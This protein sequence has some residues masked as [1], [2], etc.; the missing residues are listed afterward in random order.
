MDMGNKAATF[1]HV[2]NVSDLSDP[3]KKIVKVGN[4]SVALFHVSGH[5][6]ATDDRCTHDGGR[7]VSGQLN[8]HTII[9]PRH[10][11]KFDIRTGEV[12][13][14]PALVD[15]AVHEVKIENNNVLVRLS[16]EL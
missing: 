7:L 12:L 8:G 10:G 16:E 6:W 14:K 3:G 4:R 9:C 5:F 15:L 11:A 2:C 1:I 13:S